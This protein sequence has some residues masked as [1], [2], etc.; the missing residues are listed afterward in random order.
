MLDRLL[1]FPSQEVAAQIGAAMGYSTNV[2]GVWK[3]TQATESLGICVIGEHRGD[4]KWWVMVRS[5]LDIPVPQSIQQFIVIPDDGN[6][7]IPNRK[8]A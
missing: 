8:W 7:Q 1:C 5:L 3:T 4:G 2:G 6:P